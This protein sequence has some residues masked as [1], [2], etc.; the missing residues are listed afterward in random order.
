MPKGMVDARM[1]LHL[2]PAGSDVHT[3]GARG[4]VVDRGA[5][6][7]AAIVDEDVG[8]PLVSSLRKRRSSAALAKAT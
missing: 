5:V 1:P 6:L 4:A 7:D 2:S 8:H 3:L